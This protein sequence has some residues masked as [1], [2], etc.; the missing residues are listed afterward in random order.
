MQ[1]AAGSSGTLFSRRPLAAQ[2]GAALFACVCT[3]PDTCRP[4]AL[5]RS[6]LALIDL[7]APGQPPAASNTGAAS[8]L[9]SQLQPCVAHVAASVATAFRH[10]SLKLLLPELHR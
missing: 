7:L 6:Q 4:R 3:Q 1:G 8:N 9:P 2:I 5:P 10:S